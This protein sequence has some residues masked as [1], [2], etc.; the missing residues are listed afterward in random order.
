MAY[1]NKN[2][3]ENIVTKLLKEEMIQVP[4]LMVEDVWKDF[5][6]TEN[7]EVIEIATKNRGKIDRLI[8]FETKKM[9]EEYEKDN[10]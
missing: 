5:E 7:E 3:L 8:K 2:R 4:E 6:K 9:M 1:V 10:E